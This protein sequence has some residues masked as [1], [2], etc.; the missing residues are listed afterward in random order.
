MSTIGLIIVSLLILATV[1]ISLGFK[2]CPEPQNIIEYRF[3]PR[4]LKE[5][6]LEPVSVVNLYSKIFSAD[7]VLPYRI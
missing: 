5:E 4:T 1:L 7:N 2:K 3:V 6:Q